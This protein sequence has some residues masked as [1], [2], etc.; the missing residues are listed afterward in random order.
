MRVIINSYFRSQSVLVVIAVKSIKI[1]LHRV[2][3]RRTAN[4]VRK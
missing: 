1:V 2:P 3:G 4:R